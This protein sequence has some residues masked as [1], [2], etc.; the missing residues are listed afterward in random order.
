MQG[1]GDTGM[2]RLSGRCTAPPVHLLPVPCGRNWIWIVLIALFV[3]SAFC[4]DLQERIKAYLAENLSCRAIYRRGCER[5]KIH[6]NASVL[7]RLSDD[8]GKVCFTF[9]LIYSVSRKLRRFACVY[10]ELAQE[11]VRFSSWGV[12]V[13][14]ARRSL[15]HLPPLQATVLS[16]RATKETEKTKL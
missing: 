16:I 1:R 3:L 2:L 15:N 13:C 8:P 14:F 6:P 5:M 12:H 9:A 7:Q 11:Q 10:Q 4:A